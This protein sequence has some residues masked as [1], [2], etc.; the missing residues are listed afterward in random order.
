MSE[1]LVRMTIDVWKGTEP[2]I[3]WVQV[4]RRTPKCIYYHVLRRSSTG[5]PVKCERTFPARRLNRVVNGSLGRVVPGVHAIRWIQDDRE[6]IKGG[7]AY[8]MALF[9][10]LEV[11]N[12]HFRQAAARIYDLE[13]QLADAWKQRRLQ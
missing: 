10:V 9:N 12:A 3:S 5:Q 6:P 2:E 1:I 11:I 4:S 13:G 8:N 7:E